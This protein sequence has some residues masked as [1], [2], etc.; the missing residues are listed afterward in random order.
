MNTM[1]LPLPGVTF[2]FPVGKNPHLYF[3]L[4]TPLKRE[5]EKKVL[6]VNI[7]SVK[8]KREEYTLNV[9]DHEFIKHE[10][11]INYSKAETV[12]VENLKR[13]L[14]RGKLKIKETVA[15]DIVKFICEGLW[16]SRYSTKQAKSFCKEACEKGE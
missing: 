11:Y 3:I 6:I 4:T 14:R 16:K 1:L 8:I 7:T 5:G 12:S 15:M 13:N 9:G 10:S 2:L